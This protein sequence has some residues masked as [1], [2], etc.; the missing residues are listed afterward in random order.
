LP[1]TN[2]KPIHIDITGKGVIVEIIVHN[3][4]RTNDKLKQQNFYLLNQY[5]NQYSEYP[6]SEYVSAVKSG[7]TSESNL[8]PD[9]KARYFVVFDINPD[10][11]ALM[12]VAK[13]EFDK[14]E[15]VFSLDL[16]QKIVM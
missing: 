16:D 6:M 12:L 11:V 13:S 8:R 3:N 1:V 14:N 4:K 10:S 9:V 2:R 7:I 5:L 15:V